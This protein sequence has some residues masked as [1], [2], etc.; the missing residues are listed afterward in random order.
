MYFVQKPVKSRR[1]EIAG[2]YSTGI[3]EFDKTFILADIAQVQKLNDWTSNQ[4]SGFEVIIDEFDNLD[5]MTSEVFDIVGTI[6]EEDKDQLKV[7]NIRENYRQIFDWLKLS[8]T[9]VWVILGIML[10]VGGFNMISGLLVIILE[11]TNMIGILKALGS[12]NL[13]IR[14]IFIYYAAFL[15]GKGL[16][17]GNLIGIALCLLQ[18]Y[19]GFFQLDPASYYIDVVPINLKVI[20]LALLNLGTLLITIVMLIVPSVIIARISPIK[21]IKFT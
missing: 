20:H 3:E 11:R 17:W 13:S 8:D 19:T 12:K 18:Y 6:Y 14:K 2:I 15:I 1:F 9:N 4:V 7:K 16:F 21:A 10:I 5:M